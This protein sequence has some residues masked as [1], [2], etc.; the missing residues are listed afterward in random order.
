MFEVWSLEFEI[1]GF[2]FLG[3]WLLGFWAFGIL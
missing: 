2:W 1:F 3:F